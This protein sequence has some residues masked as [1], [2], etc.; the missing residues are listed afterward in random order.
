MSSRISRAAAPSRTI[1]IFGVTVVQLD[2]VHILTIDRPV[3]VRLLERL[4]ETTHAE[5]REGEEVP[6]PPTGERVLVLGER[7]EPSPRVLQPAR[8]VH[9]DAF[10]EP[11]LDVRELRIRRQPR[12][13]L[14]KPGRPPARLREVGACGRCQRELDDVVAHL[15]RV[16][17]G[18]E[19]LPEQTL[20]APPAAAHQGE[21]RPAEQLAAL[22]RRRVAPYGA[23]ASQ[24]TWK[25]FCTRRS[26]GRPLSSQP[27]G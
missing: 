6:S 13:P 22:R 4:A 23:R 2:P 27:M 9:V 12:E 26:V 24:R 7:R 5:E 18:R 17:R 10:G 3:G 15:G 20:P 14:A 1:Q 11:A 19:V 16:G 25:R 21:A 8:V